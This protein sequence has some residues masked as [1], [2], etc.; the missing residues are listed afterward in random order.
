MYPVLQIWIR[1]IL[2]DPDPTIAGCKELKLSLKTT[3]WDLKGRCHDILS[4]C[5]PALL[6]SNPKK[7]ILLQ[8]STVQYSTVQYSTV[9]CL[10]ILNQ[11]SI[12]FLKKNIDQTFQM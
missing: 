12:N 8:Y 2:P 11:Y 3:L 4:I 6:A 5:S 7:K 10:F 9:G 1:Y